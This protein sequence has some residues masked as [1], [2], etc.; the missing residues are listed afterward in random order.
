MENLVQKISFHREQYL[1]VQLSVLD[2][3]ALFVTIF[4]TLDRVSNCAVTDTTLDFQQP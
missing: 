3:C 2:N 4:A 1:V